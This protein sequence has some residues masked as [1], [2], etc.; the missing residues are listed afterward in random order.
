[1]AFDSTGAAVSFQGTFMRAIRSILRW[2]AV[3]PLLL[4][5]ASGGEPIRFSKGSDSGRVATRPQRS[6]R[7]ALGLTENATF[8]LNQPA[9]PT[10]LPAAPATTRAALPVDEDQRNWIFQDTQSEAGRQRA[11]GIESEQDNPASVSAR[12]STTIIQE[13]FDRQ[14]SG[15]ANA[16]NP[17]APFGNNLTPGAGQSLQPGGPANSNPFAMDASQELPRAGRVFG[18]DTFQTTLNAENLAVRRAFRNQYLSQGSMA[19]SSLNAPQQ[20]AEASANLSLPGP[21]L[22]AGAIPG[23]ASPFSELAA[24]ASLIESLSPSSPSSSPATTLQPP[25]ARP[26]GSPP[27]V[28]DQPIFERRGGLIEIPGRKF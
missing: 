18:Q 24:R 13:Y 27:E 20:P 21:P 5:T 26:P 14:R 25:A 3:A 17:G 23:Q 7:E 1:M 15:N 9:A 22:A 12:D 19:P 2:A 28:D 16:G 10:V 6:A 11:F 4:L 8:T